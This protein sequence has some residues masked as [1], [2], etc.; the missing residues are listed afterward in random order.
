MDINNVIP[1]SVAGDSNLGKMKT[2]LFDVFLRLYDDFSTIIE[3]NDL[4]QTI[5]IWRCAS[6]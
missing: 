1:L 2:G 5:P 3:F 4:E 6:K